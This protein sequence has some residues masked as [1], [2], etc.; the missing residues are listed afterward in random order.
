MGSP[1]LRAPSPIPEGRTGAQFEIDVG[2]IVRQ[3]R[4][5]A[6]GPW[7]RWDGGC[8]STDCARRGTR[9]EI[10]TDASIRRACGAR[11]WGGRRPHQRKIGRGTRDLQQAGVDQ[12]EKLVR[13]VR[14]PAIDEPT[15][16][17]S[18]QPKARVLACPLAADRTPTPCP[19]RNR[20]STPA[21]P[22]ARA[23]GASRTAAS[24]WRRTR[25]R[26]PC[27]PGCRT[28]PDRAGSR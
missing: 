15:V 5:A 25:C 8:A 19:S 24:A 26:P 14:T 28:S 21:A 1:G 23:R 7:N 12:V 27:P 16:A 2:E 11:A 13:R 17:S 6:C 22:A 3:A 4:G 20:R 18:A 9:P 10:C